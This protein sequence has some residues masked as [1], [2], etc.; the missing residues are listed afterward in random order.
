MKRF[1][2]LLLA[3]L[4]VAACGETK[5]KPLSEPGEKLYVM[6]G[7][8]LSRDARANSLNVD[9][10]AIPGFMEAMAMEYPVRGAQVETLPPDSAEI[11]AKLHVTERS[12][13]L[14]DVK[15]AP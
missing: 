7:K 6:Q 2:S 14:T 1:A 4:F 3:A 5:P 8:I 9:H 10:R 12:Y 15:K 13:W 11:V